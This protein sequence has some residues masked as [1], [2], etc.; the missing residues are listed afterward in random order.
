MSCNEILPV[1]KVPSFISWE[2][3]KHQRIPSQ[4]CWKIATLIIFEKSLWRSLILDAKFSRILIISSIIENVES[5]F[6]LH[7]SMKSQ[8][9]SEILKAAIFKNICEW[10]ISE[11][12][13]YVNIPI[14]LSHRDVREDPEVQVL[15]HLLLHHR[16]HLLP[17]SMSNVRIQYLHCTKNKVFY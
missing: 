2:L 10:L 12:I 6:Y 14:G 17:K 3:N 9:L 4:F 13:E 1:C 7:T 8:Y 16:I 5:I 15:L 11:A